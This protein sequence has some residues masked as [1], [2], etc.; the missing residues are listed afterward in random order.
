MFLTAKQT[1]GGLPKARQG[2][3]LALP[4]AGCAQADVP[5]SGGA[6]PA[7]QPRRENT[8]D[9]PGRMSA[10]SGQLGWPRRETRQGL[11]FAHLFARGRRFPRRVNATVP[12]PISYGRT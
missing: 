7:W 10:T 3:S 8:G 4:A 12:S 11:S 5:A 6:K 9:R 1:P 2:T